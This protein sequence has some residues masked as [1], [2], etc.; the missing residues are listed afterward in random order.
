M[1]IEAMLLVFAEEVTEDFEEDTS[2]DDEE[3]ANVSWTQLAPGFATCGNTNAAG[4]TNAASGS[5]TPAVQLVGSHASP[6]G[7]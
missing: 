6:Q 4:S 7:G 3:W 1:E 2:R 5:S